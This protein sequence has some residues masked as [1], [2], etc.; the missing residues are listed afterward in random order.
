MCKNLAED[1]L[2]YEYDS[3]YDDIS[4]NNRNK[5]KNQIS[6]ENNKPK[7]FNDIMKAANKRKVEQSIVLEKLEAKK[8]TEEKSQFEYSNQIW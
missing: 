7:Y 6:E 4:S 1:S 3:I 5:Y 8:R 2:T